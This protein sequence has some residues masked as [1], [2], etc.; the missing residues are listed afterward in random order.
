MR[1]F[2]WAAAIALGSSGTAFAQAPDARAELKTPRTAVIDYDAVRATK[3]VRAIRI[4]EKMAI[5]GSLNE[6]AWQRATPATGFIQW[7][8]S[9]GGLSPVEREG[10]FL[11]DD[12]SRYDGFH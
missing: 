7:S 6:R 12:G 1:A 11:Y 2:T 4:G 3:I 8:P 5:D 10:R 9:P